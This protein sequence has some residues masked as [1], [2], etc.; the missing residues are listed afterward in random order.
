M[1]GPFFAIA[2]L[3]CQGIMPTFS[4]VKSPFSLV[5]SPFSLVES[6]FG[7]DFC[8]E[9]QVELLDGLKQVPKET[10]QGCREIY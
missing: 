1:F 4:L 2:M 5:K 6:T 3:N 10:F 7:V 9:S 8:S